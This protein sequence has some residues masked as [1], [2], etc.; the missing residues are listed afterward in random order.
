MTPFTWPWRWEV[1]LPLALWAGLYT[2][3]WYRLYR[4]GHRRLASWWALAVHTAA[5]LAVVLAL[6]TPVYTWSRYLFSVNMAHHMLLL[7]VAPPLF[8]LAR[9]F[10]I[11]LWTLPRGVRQR[12]PRG[13]ASGR[14]VREA[15]RWLTN[16]GLAW[17]VFA[18][19]FWTW[20]TPEMYNAAMRRLFL[21]DL[22]HATFFF[23]ALL[24]WWHVV[25]A[26]PRWHGRISY[27]WRIGYVM[28]ALAQNEI[29]AVA[30]TFANTL[31]YTYYQEV[32]RLWGLSPLD[33]QRL[34]GAI[35][36]V[37]GGMMYGIAA[38]VLLYKIIAAEEK[39]PPL[40][41]EYWIPEGPNG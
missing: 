38:V 7:M 33:D 13:L 26:A 16:P 29:L 25:A 14:A 18:A 30:I 28:A 3:G 10:P 15:I 2:A 27:G 35:M 1:A 41:E 23:T 24:F 19:T 9:P 4:R 20:H 12:L 22:Q 17:L 34:G 8:W 11:L 36:W 5:V 32:P 6:L 39:K 31:W 40:P 21:E 37:P